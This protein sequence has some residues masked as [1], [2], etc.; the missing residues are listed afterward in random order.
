MQAYMQQNNGCAYCSACH[1][2]GKA[3]CGANIH[4]PTPRISVVFGPRY[5]CTDC[6]NIFCV[7]KEYTSVVSY[8]P[9][10]IK[11]RPD[12]DNLWW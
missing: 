8:Y 7:S 3:Q 5:Y 10:P 1:R 6:W 4:G 2:C 9:R 12:D 11:T